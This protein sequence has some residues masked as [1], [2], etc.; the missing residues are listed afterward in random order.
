MITFPNAKINLGIN[1]V[2]KRVDGY[3]NIE[4]LFY[5][6]DLCDI[7]EIEISDHTALTIVGR[8]IEGDVE[9]N[10]VMR[11][12]RHMQRSYA[13]PEMRITLDKQIPMGAGL[14]GGSADAAFTLKMVNDIC[15]LQLTDEQLA[16]A[17]VTLGA[18]C[19]FFIYNRPMLAS[20]IGDTL[21][22]SRVNLDGYHLA[23]IKPDIHVATAD[24]YRGCTPAP[25]A[26]PL[27]DIVKTP[28]SEW[29][30]TLVNDFER[31]V[32]ANH[33]TLLSI[34]NMLYDMGATYA[35][36]SGSGSSIY[37]LFTSTP[38]ATD[39]NDR[40]KTIRTATNSFIHIE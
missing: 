11:A 38:T 6:I 33:P 17:A 25:W 40:L 18:D 7:L 2:N 34:K 8:E 12:L 39:I 3:H 5:P 32:F 10:L 22:P 23:L 24:A 29:R 13:V 14:G 4:T 19:P 15:H 9:A 21:T 36:M 28:I 35:S 27:S 30:H 37:G 16:E 1:I 20:G 26:T 31:Q